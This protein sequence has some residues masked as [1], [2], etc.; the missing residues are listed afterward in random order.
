MLFSVLS[1]IADGKGTSLRFGGAVMLQG[2]PAALTRIAPGQSVDLGTT[3][4]E[5]VEGGYPEA[6]YAYRKMLDEK[7]CRFPKDFNP[8]VHWEQLYDMPERLGR[9]PAPLHEGDCRAR[10]GEGARLQLRGALSRSRLG[11]RLRQFPLG[12]EVARP[13]K[14]VHRRNAVEVRAEGVAAHAAGHLDVAYDAELGASAP[15]RPIRRKPGGFRPSANAAS[16]TR[17]PPCAT[18]GATWPCCRRPKP[19]P[20]RCMTTENGRSIKRRISTTAGTATTRVGSP[21]NLPAWAE[22]DLGAEY[23]IAEVRLGNDHLGQFTDRGATELKILAATKYNADSQAADWRDGRR[24]PRR[25]AVC[26]RRS[27][28]FPATTARWVRVDI[29]KTAAGRRAAAG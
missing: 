8:P 5:T 18:A 9:P 12:R 28:R 21:T 7:G 14:A 20:R 6:M 13:A 3:R 23:E 17:F 27:S 10:S 2:E 29:L 11:H 15:C 1:T 25:A 19:T 24:I 16:P 26:R 22:I 4:F